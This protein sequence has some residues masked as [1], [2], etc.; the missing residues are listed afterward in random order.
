[1][2]SVADSKSVTKKS[3]FHVFSN[4]VVALKT[5]PKKV[6]K[7]SLSLPDAIFIALLSLHTL[8]LLSADFV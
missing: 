8:P 3:Q 6:I 5:K 2:K 7:E 1:M 4:F